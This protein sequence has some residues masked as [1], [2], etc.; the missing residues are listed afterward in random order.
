M[1]GRFIP[2]S[3]SRRLVCDVLHFAARI[4]TIPV[5]RRMAL[6]DLVEARRSAAERPPW[7]VIFARGFA[8]VA[9]EIPEFR[10]AYCS[11][12]WPHLYEYPTSVAAVTVE[13]DYQGD[14]TVLFL[15]IKD[16]AS[17]SIPELAA[18]LH[19]GAT[20]PIDSVKDFR[21]A[22]RLAGLP[23][24]VRRTIWWFGLNAGRQRAN[25]FG[26]FAVSVSSALGSES[27]HPLSPLAFTINYG[28]VADDGS[29]NV[30]IVYDHRVLDG[31][32]VARGLLRLEEILRT[33]VL[34]EVRALIPVR[35]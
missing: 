29:V 30:R 31:A 21:R 26:T 16:P 12:P 14:K 25:Y 5:Q 4:P 22:L 34:A 6:Q 35:R 33:T 27:L 8:L 23:R 10:R 18:R 1:K 28:V 3:R 2:L 24:P 13:R 9:S 20:A 7:P 15:R 19:E 17:L 32:T 11:W